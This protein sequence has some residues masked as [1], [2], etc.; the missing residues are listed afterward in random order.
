MLGAEAAS[1]GWVGPVTMI[2]LVGL[3]VVL[4]A[5][6]ATADPV[7]EDWAGGLR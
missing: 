6:K 4:W 5:R 7:S 1:A 3:I 2:I